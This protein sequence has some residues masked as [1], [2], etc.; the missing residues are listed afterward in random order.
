MTE[1]EAI[2][3]AR[4]TYSGNADLRVTFRLSR[5]FTVAQVAQKHGWTDPMT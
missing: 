3:T 1:D 2:D 4:R 5:G